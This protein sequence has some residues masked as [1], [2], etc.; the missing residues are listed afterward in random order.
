MINR[1]KYFIKD[2]LNN[3][4]YYKIKDLQIGGHCGCCGAWIN[5]EIFPAYW[6]IGICKNCMR[7]N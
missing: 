7:E 5:D 4:G 1:I 6:A 2:T 3:K